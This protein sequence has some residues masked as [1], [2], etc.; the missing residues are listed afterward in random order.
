MRWFSIV[1][2]ATDRIS[3]IS[4]GVGAKDIIVMR[5][6]GTDN[7]SRSPLV[8]SPPV[9]AESNETGTPI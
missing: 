3:I 5:E 7:G 4:V 2:D 1:A 8:R 9:T 6:N